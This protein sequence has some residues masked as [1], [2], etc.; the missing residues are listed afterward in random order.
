MY[1]PYS[2]PSDTLSRMLNMYPSRSL[3]F[4]SVSMMSFISAC[5]ENSSSWRF[6]KVSSLRPG[7]PVTVIFRSVR[8][9]R[10]FVFTTS[11]HSY[12]F[13]GTFFS[14]S[15]VSPSVLPLVGDPFVAPSSSCSSF[16]SNFVSSAASASGFAS[17][18]GDSPPSGDFFSG[19]CSSGGNSRFS[20]TVSWYSSSSTS[21]ALSMLKVP[22]S[23]S[24]ALTLTFLGSGAGGNST[25]N[26]P[27]SFGVQGSNRAGSAYSAF[28]SKGPVL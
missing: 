5:M 25:R 9:V 12:F 18:T 22:C 21:C 23:V 15:L 14:G 28:T 10:F 16:S 13:S 7:R 3:R 6:C 2:M 27:S 24:F 17:G 20:F 26:V 19:S 1:G 8:F 4:S 11:I